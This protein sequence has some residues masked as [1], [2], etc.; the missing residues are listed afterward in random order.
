MTAEQLRERRQLPYPHWT[1]HPHHTS[2][3]FLNRGASSLF[4]NDLSHRVAGISDDFFDLRVTERLPWLRRNADEFR[5]QI[6]LDRGHLGLFP[7]CL[8]DS[9]RTKGADHPVDGGV[10]RFG[11]GR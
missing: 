3:T 9:G 7:E 8:F 2:P 5:V 10:N 1:T 4:A 11:Q 6:N